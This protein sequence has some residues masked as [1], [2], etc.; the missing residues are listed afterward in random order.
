M[1]IKIEERVVPLPLKGEP[2]LARWWMGVLRFARKQP[3]GA[4]C[5]VVLLLMVAVALF[6]DAIAPYS[7]TRNDVGPSL[8]GPSADHWFGTDQFGRDLFSRVAH[9]ARVSLYVGLVTTLIG[10]VLATLLGALSGYLGGVFDYILQRFVD[11]AQAIPPLVLLIGVLVVLGPSVQNV[12]IALA[13]RNALSLSRVVRG[14]VIGVRSSPYI[15]AVRAVGAS[16]L[17]TLM[18]HI[19]PNILP[20]VVVLVSTTIGANIVAE[21]SLSFLGYGVPPPRPT[22]GGMMSAEGRI[23]MLASPWILVFPTIALSIVVFAMNM[24]G[25]ALRDEIDPR[26]RGSR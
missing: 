9:G 18:L 5:A 23:Y 6:A 26:M 13:F 19:L 17:R 4:V 12:I 24:F 3:V 10:V 8:T 11:A 2:L 16:H 14:A 25:D 1:T 22:W 7:P 20:T 21:A 15:D